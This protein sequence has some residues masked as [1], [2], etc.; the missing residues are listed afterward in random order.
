MNTVQ[1]IHS[2]QVF[3]FKPL[4]FPPLLQRFVNIVHY[5][6]TNVH[7]NVLIMA[8]SKGK[9]SKGTN[10]SELQ[11][12]DMAFRAYLS[13]IKLP[14][15]PTTEH[16]TFVECLNDR[17]FMVQVI[18]KGITYSLFEEIQKLTSLTSQNWAEIL[19]LSTRSL[20]RYKEQDQLFKPIQSEKIIEL[21]E[22][23]I[24]GN[25]VF[26]DEKKFKSWLETPNFALGS[27]KPSDLMGDSFGQE[28]LM[29]E[30]HRISH[31]ILA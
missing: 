3:F 25:D 8:T 27:V 31:G 7:S 24:L 1:L 17:L 2:V 18:K 6:W 13:R 20:K 5:F 26:G 23:F 22:L 14:S 9:S 11:S 21:G 28:L 29:Q 10:T 30:L 19:N 16:V 4:N 15:L 12:L